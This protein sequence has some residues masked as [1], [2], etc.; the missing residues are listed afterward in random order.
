MVEIVIESML[1]GRFNEGGDGNRK[2][3]KLKDFERLPYLAF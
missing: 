2:S 1:E 3:C